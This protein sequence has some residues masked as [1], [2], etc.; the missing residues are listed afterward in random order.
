MSP[1][2]RFIFFQKD[3]E[4][5]LKQI[6]KLE[7]D[8]KKW[9]Q[10]STEGK[11]GDWHDNFNYEEA[12]RQMGSLSKQIH[13]LEQILSKVEVLKEEGPAI[14]N[15][16]RAVVGCKVTLEDENGTQNKFF[17]GSYMVLRANPDINGYHAISYVSPLGRAI[18]GKQLDDEVRF[19]VEGNEQLFYIVD[20]K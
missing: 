2:D 15:P 18:L 1:S 5:L 16:E 11:L 9:G 8:Y 3:C 17:L 10:I 12:M 20:I 13:E 19:R 7:A 14:R 4:A 6:D